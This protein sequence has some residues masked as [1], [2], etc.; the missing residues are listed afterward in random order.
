MI[1]LLVL[2][3]IHV[4]ATYCMCKI[5]GLS[6][7]GGVTGSLPTDSEFQRKMGVGI[8]FF[9]FILWSKLTI[10]QIFRGVVMFICNSK[11]DEESCDTVKTYQIHYGIIL[12]GLGSASSNV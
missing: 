4:N 3:K 5:G 1:A 11:N 12:C 7:F 10:L 9:F 6:A 2:F 8:C